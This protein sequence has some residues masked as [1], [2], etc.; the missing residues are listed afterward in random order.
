MLLAGRRGAGLAVWL[1]SGW[2]WQ[3]TPCRPRP[4]PNH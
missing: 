3:A 2:D 1:R 4:A